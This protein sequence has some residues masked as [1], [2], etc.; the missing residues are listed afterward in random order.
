M[1]ILAQ[2][3]AQ[4]LGCEFGWVP[5]KMS[6]KKLPREGFHRPGSGVHFWANHWWPGGGVGKSKEA[7]VGLKWLRSEEQFSKGRGTFSREGGC[8]RQTKQ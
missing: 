7:P 1:V 2:C 6:F 4:V 8:A 5:D 3:S